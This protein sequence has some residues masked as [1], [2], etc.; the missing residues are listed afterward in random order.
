MHI[1]VYF[2]RVIPLAISLFTRGHLSRVI[3]SVPVPLSR[4]GSRGSWELQS[5]VRQYMTLVECVET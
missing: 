5:L 2:C 4:K 3:L 1:R